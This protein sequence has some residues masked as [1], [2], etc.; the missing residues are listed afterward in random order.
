LQ[1]LIKSINDSGSIVKDIF[2]QL[3]DIEYGAYNVKNKS[4]IYEIDG[5]KE[6]FLN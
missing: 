6:L 3:D 4:F 1:A 5:T 2:H